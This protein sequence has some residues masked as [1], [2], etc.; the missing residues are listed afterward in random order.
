V[1]IGGVLSGILFPFLLAVIGWRGALLAF[2][3][4]MLLVAA[5]MFPAGKRFDREEFA[6]PAHARRSVR[7]SFATMMRDA[8]LL[9]LTIAAL[10]FV[11]AQVCFNTF[12]VTYLATDL[13]M[14]IVLAGAVLASGQV[15]GLIGRVLWGALSGRLLPPTV[16]LLLLGL[17]MTAGLAALGTYGASLSLP[18]LH[19]A[20]FVVGLTV[21]GWNGVFLAEVA[22]LA[23]RDQVGGIT[24][25]VFALSGAGLIV[26]PFAFAV[27]AGA[28]SYGAA[29]L[30]AAAWTAIGA[31]I[32][33]LTLVR[34]GHRAP[35]I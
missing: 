11:S 34:R 2:A 9:W 26:G 28:S 32:L 4:F 1:Q 18:A 30:M 35:S 14:S 8:R 19:S 24:G 25:A 17:V 22:R 20:S 16:L 12:L 6:V 13:G 23:P 15:G 7:Q 31:G 5:A 29:Y 27:L 3:L 33:A 10:M 21:S